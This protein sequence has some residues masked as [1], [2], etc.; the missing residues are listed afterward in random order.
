MSL[1]RTL[2]GLITTTG[3]VKSAS[4]DNVSAGLTVYATLDDLPTTGLTSGDQAYVSA[5][6][7]F[8]I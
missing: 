1:N 3:D 6:S 7:R 8:Y 4:L 2:A 5:T